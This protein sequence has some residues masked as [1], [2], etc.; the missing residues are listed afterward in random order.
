MAEEQPRGR[1]GR[2]GGY[3]RR[4]PCHGADANEEEPR[5]NRILDY[6]RDVNRAEEESEGS[7]TDSS[8][9]SV[10]KMRTH[11]V[12]TNGIKIVV[13]GPSRYRS[14]PNLGVKV[15][16]P[17]FEGLGYIATD[18]PNQKII[19]IIEEDNGPI[20]D[21]YEDD[22]YRQHSDQAEIMY[23]DCGEALVV[24]RNLSMVTEDNESWLRHNIFHTRC[25]CLGKVCNVII[26]GGS[27]ENLISSIMVDKLGLKTEEHPKLYT[28]SWFK[29]GNEVK[30]SK[31][32]LVNFFIGKTYTDEVW[33][34][35]VLMKACH[36]F[37]GRPWQF[38]YKTKHDG[39]KNTYT[40][41]KDGTTITLGPLDLRKEARNQFLSRAEFLTEAH[42][43]NS[44]FALIMVEP[45]AGTYNILHEVKLVLEEFKDVV[46]EELPPGLPPM[47]DIQHCINFVP[48]AVIP[49]KAAYQ[50]NPKEHEELQRK[51]QHLLEKGSI[52]ESLSPCAVPAL[53]VPKK[54]GH[55]SLRPIP[56]L[57][58]PI[59]ECIKG[60]KF[61]LSQEAD[62]A[63]GLLKNKV[64]TAHVL[65]LP[66]FNEVFE[67]HCDASGVGSGVAPWVDVSIEFVLGLP[68]R[69]RN[70]E[71]IMVVVDRFSKMAHF[72]P[73]NKTFDASQVARLLLHEVVRL[74]GVPKTIT[75]DR[76]LEK[77]PDNG[78]WYCHKPSLHM[79][80]Q[81]V[82]L[83]ERCHPITPLDLTPIVTPAHFCSEG[84]E[85]AKQVQQL[86]E[87]VRAHIE[88]Q[89]AKYKKRV[90][91]I[92]KKVVFKEGDLNIT[93]NHTLLDTNLCV[94]MMAEP[95]DFAPPDDVP[96]S[97]IDSKFTA[98]YVVDLI[99]VTNSRGDHT[100]TD[101]QSGVLFT[102]ASRTELAIIYQSILT[103][104][105]QPKDVFTHKMHVKDK[106]LVKVSPNVDYAFVSTLVSV[107]EAMKWSGV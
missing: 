31:R 70:I 42:E 23:V 98:S 6:F 21:E 97:V 84:E 7:D 43:A 86:H 56:N 37:L 5:P 55:R 19:T 26:N 54:D 64:T 32:C 73:C 3:V 90:D 91:K 25:T 45:N 93:I 39:F 33:C 1:R 105:N 57:A 107:I 14:S 83:Q 92:R 49:H 10:K 66:D 104:T 58:L 106:F 13:T 46:S 53:L 100:I 80:D 35:V 30:V 59:T 4:Q 27:Y 71:L 62:E 38:D 2:R 65:T 22:T 81:K 52:R 88:K 11:E 103:R 99:F 78:I 50:M 9:S 75:S 69:Q 72:I 40:F 96:I 89:N 12:L 67:V 94:L 15:D 24:R 74:H 51:V 8:E 17:N 76:D 41:E 44:M 82:A 18:C 95:S 85:Q 102:A 101:G 34:D 79:T 28:L 63:F 47:R 36:I 16:I 68:R 60:S 29:K 48:G 20:F 87:N 77:T 61:N